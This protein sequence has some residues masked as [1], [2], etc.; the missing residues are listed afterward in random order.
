MKVTTL[1]RGVEDTSFSLSGECPHCSKSAVLTT[2]GSI[3]SENVQGEGQENYKEQTKRYAA[4]MQ[5][6]G[7]LKFVLAVVT[8]AASAQCRSAH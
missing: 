7:C 2:C 5:C 8:R 4:I 6:P 3:Y 1:S